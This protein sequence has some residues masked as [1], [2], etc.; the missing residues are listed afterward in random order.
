VPVSFRALQPA[1][2]HNLREPRRIESSNGTPPAAIASRPSSSS[3]SSLVS[4][5]VLFSFPKFGATLS[6]QPRTRERDVRHLLAAAV[7]LIVLPGGRTHQRA[8]STATGTAA[9]AAAPALRS[10]S[11]RLDFTPRPPHPP[12]SPQLHLPSHF[13]SGPEHR[14]PQAQVKVQVGKALAPAVGSKRHPPPASASVTFSPFR[15]SPPHHH[16]IANSILLH[17]RAPSL[18]S[19]AARPPEPSVIHHDS[20]RTPGRGDVLGL[21]TPGTLHPLKL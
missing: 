16:S 8:Y 3:S 15:T 11:G 14:P 21:L 18:P 1:D 4:A 12:R 19:S 17:C 13:F 20:L 5:P 9:A 10:Q 2:A 7:L 6:H